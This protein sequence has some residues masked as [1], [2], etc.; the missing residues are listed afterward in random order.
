MD[1]PL[2][3]ACN[4]PN[5]PPLHF[6]T[7]GEK[8]PK[9]LKEP[10]GLQMPEKALLEPQS[11]LA[12]G[13]WGEMELGTVQRPWLLGGCVSHLSWASQPSASRTF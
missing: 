5:V 7:V 8:L 11:A 6:I 12:V 9:L 13:C 2:P 10:G 4:T 3:A 1:P